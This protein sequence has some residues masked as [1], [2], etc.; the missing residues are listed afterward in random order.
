MH[1]YCKAHWQPLATLTKCLNPCFNGRCTRTITFDP[2]SR[3]DGVLILVLM[4][5]ALVLPGEHSSGIHLLCLNPCF[6]GRC[7]RTYYVSDVAGVFGGLNPCFNGRCTRTSGGNRISG[8]NPQV[9]ILVLME[10]ALVRSNY[11]NK[12]WR[13]ES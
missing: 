10:D 12:K 7:T 6:N 13:V 1:S 5:D 11:L 8:Q 4:E 3:N 9:L 2:T